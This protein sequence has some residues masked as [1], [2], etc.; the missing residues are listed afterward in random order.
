[1][2]N[3]ITNI[4]TLGKNNLKFFDR[5]ANR[6][7]LDNKDRKDLINQINKSDLR[8]FKLRIPRLRPITELS[9]EQ[10]DKV[11]NFFMLTTDSQFFNI[12]TILI[13]TDVPNIQDYLKYTINFELFK[14]IASQ[15]VSKPENN[16]FAEL[17]IE[18]YDN[19]ITY[20][21]QT[22]TEDGLGWTTPEII[23][24]ELDELIVEKEITKEEYYKKVYDT[25]NYP[26]E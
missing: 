13:L 23:T 19:K 26:K 1:M 24:F 10:R 2:K 9:I 17:Y 15:I 20:I 16:T 11:L 22:H 18:C 25:T 3:R 4:F 6:Y 5:I 21:D 7:N 14:T 8:Y 12:K